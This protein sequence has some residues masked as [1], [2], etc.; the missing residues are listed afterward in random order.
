M[1]S[2]LGTSEAPKLEGTMGKSKTPLGQINI[3]DYLTS[4]GTKESKNAKTLFWPHV[5]KTLQGT[6]RRSRI[7]TQQ[8]TTHQFFKS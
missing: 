2:N 5:Y 3:I 7:N 1:G 4:I 8:K 6:C